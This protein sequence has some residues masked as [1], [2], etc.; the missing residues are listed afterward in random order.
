MNQ[1]NGKD[2]SLVRIIEGAQKQI[3]GH[4]SRSLFIYLFIYLLHDLYRANFENQVRGAG[5]ARWRT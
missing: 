5:V 3:F 2:S 4:Y 1:Y